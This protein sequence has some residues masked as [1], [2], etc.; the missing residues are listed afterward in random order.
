MMTILQM[1]T[2]GAFT[3]KKM[4]ESFLTYFLFDAIQRLIIDNMSASN[5]FS[6]RQQATDGKEIGKSAWVP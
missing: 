5:S 6:N 4:S 3:W 2:S 1:M